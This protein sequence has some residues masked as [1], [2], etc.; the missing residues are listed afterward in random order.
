[1]NRER[2]GEREG[3]RERRKKGKNKNIASTNETMYR[4]V[5]FIGI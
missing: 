4:R 2:V 5:N 3:G 1:M